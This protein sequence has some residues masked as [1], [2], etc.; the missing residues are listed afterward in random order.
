MPLYLAYGPKVCARELSYRRITREAPTPL[1]QDDR[2][3]P[4]ESVARYLQISKALSGLETL[5][6]GRKR[7][8]GDNKSTM[9]LCCTMI[10]EH[11]SIYLKMS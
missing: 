8:D 10:T 4:I 7:M 3:G 2:I 5:S 11:K 6:D 9:L 1:K